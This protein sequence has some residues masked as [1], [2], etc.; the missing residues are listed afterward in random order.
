MGIMN[1][2]FLFVNRKPVELSFSM[3]STLCDCI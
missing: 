1:D 3:K 2:E